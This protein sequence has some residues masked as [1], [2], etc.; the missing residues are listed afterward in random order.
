MASLGY[1]VGSFVFLSVL[2]I[3][4][5]IV[6]ACK[7]ST[8]GSPASPAIKK[9]NKEGAPADAKALEE[10]PAP[11]PYDGAQG[12]FFTGESA[13][14][15]AP[16]K[17]AAD[18]IFTILVPSKKA[19]EEINVRYGGGR[20][21]RAEVEASMADSP[22]RTAIIKQIEACEA[23]TGFIGF[24]APETCRISRQFT[25]STGFLLNDGRTLWT[26][27]HGVSRGMG[28]HETLNNTDAKWPIFIFDGQ[29]KLVLNSLTEKIRPQVFPEAGKLRYF[30][31]IFVPNLDYFAMALPRDIG[32]PLLKASHLPEKD[33]RIFVANY[34]HCTGC[35]A[36]SFLSG[37]FSDR[38]PMPNAD[39]KVLNFSIGKIGDLSEF[40]KFR[41][42]N[43][44]EKSYY[45]EDSLRLTNADGVGG[46]TGGPVLNESGEVVG[47]SVLASTTG[48]G[49]DK[50][51]ALTF[52]IPP[53]F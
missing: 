41:Q 15:P 3:N 10:P 53:G 20:S 37:D 24:W 38:S 27:F 5:L 50:V 31:E 33:Q 19:S 32:R 34:S 28:L 30:L 8:S 22:V 51:R 13:E 7:K 14:L 49:S 17:A 1:G 42:L 39:G 23:E 9:P 18:S 11:P 44:A 29:G 45:N 40:E 35:V 52:V 48:E 2:L 16:V 25:K 26:V 43:L 46:A 47:I 21:L 36:P 4:L 6:T 12:G